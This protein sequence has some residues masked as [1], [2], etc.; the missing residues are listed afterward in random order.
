M[1]IDVFEDVNAPGS[2][3]EREIDASEGNDWACTHQRRGVLHVEPI[4]RF[5]SGGM[6]APFISGEM[7][8]RPQ[9]G[10]PYRI[11]SGIPLRAALPI[12]LSGGGSRATGSYR[13]AW[14][15]ADGRPWI[16]ARSI[17]SGKP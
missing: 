13:R 12:R 11:N 5:A 7:S 9:R 3:A 17:V 2:P 15:F 16:V 4:I 8:Q 6:Q 10:D 1:K 14:R